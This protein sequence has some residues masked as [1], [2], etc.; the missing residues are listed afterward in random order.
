ML[1][2]NYTTRID[3]KGRIKIPATLRDIIQ[4]KYGSEFFVTSIDGDHARLYP[5]PEWAKIEE[6]LAQLPE[7]EPIKEKFEL[8]ASWYGRPATMD[9][10]GRILIHPSL[11]TKADLNGDV[12]VLGC[13]TYLQVWNHEK[14]EARV[15]AEAF[16]NEDF[17]A[18]ARLGI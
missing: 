13:R 17:A 4:Q 7:M 2:G 8:R 16:T 1:R 14:A 15:R 3:E 12:A 9:A 10:Q 11:R 6:K 18:I 5:L